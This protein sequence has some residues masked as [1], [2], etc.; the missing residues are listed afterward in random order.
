MNKTLCTVL[1]YRRETVHQARWH[2]CRKVTVSCIMSNSLSACIGVASTGQV[3]VKFGC[4]ALRKS[5]EQLHIWLKSDNTV[6]HLAW[7]HQCVKRYIYC[8]NTEN[9]LLFFH[10][11]AS[12]CI[13]ATYIRQHYKDN[14]LLRLHG[15]IYVQSLFFFENPSVYEILWKNIEPDRP[16]DNV[17]RAHG[18]L[19]TLGYRHALRICSTSCCSTARVVARMCLNVTIYLHCLSCYRSVINSWTIGQPN[20]LGGW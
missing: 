11:N 14:T 10:G 8:S 12:V 6:G 2:K 9:A 4:G 1:I 7:R 5:I 16:H 13:T 19:D 20:N 18:L 17:A 3:S 15:I